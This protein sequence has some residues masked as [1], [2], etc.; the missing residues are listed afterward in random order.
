M[1]ALVWD[2]IFFFGPGLSSWLSGVGPDSRGIREAAVYAGAVPE[3]RLTP[4]V[5]SQTLRS[6]WPP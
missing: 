1:C 6:H 4:S 2:V 3:S 5:R